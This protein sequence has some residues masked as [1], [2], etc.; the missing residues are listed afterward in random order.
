MRQLLRTLAFLCAFFGIAAQTASADNGFSYVAVRAYFG[1]VIGQCYDTI[2]NGV[3]Q[4]YFIKIA[5]TCAPATPSP[6][7]TVAPT[8]SPLP[9][10][11]PTSTPTANPAA[12]LTGG[13][14]AGDY[15]CGRQDMPV[16]TGSAGFDA[17]IAFVGEMVNGSFTAFGTWGFEPIVLIQKVNDPN[18]TVDISAISSSG[19]TVTSSSPTDNSLVRGIIVGVGLISPVGTSFTPLPAT[20][21]PV[22]TATPT[23]TPTP[24]PSP[25]STPTASPT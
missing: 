17:C 15:H 13:G 10:T 11:A 9:T 4:T 5:G 22:P 20:P 25:T 24:T 19:F 8:S 18:N 14:I 2:P 7:P 6:G 21:T 23:A 3:P 1:I 12:V 16:A